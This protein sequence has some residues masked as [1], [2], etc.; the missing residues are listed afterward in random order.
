MFF[1]RRCLVQFEVLHTHVAALSPFCD[2]NLLVHLFDAL[3]ICTQRIVA[4]TALVYL[5]LLE[6]TRYLGGPSLMWRRSESLLILGEVNLWTATSYWRFH[7]GVKV[8]EVALHQVIDK[9]TIVT[10]I[11]LR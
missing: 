3:I 8:F 11:L 1:S 6:E 10:I 4:S 7:S 9:V 5:I 2:H